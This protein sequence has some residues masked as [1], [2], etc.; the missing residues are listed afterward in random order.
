MSLYDEHER[1]TFIARGLEAYERIK[2]KLEAEHQGE[3]VAIRPETGEHFVGRTLTKANQEA[4]AADGDAWYLFVRIGEPD[5][6]I[7]LHAW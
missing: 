5:A 3:I 2:G 6:H 1:A 7:P 4:F